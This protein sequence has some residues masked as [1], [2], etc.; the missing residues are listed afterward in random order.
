M[1]NPRLG[2]HL[3]VVHANIV[4]VIVWAAPKRSESGLG[5][6]RSRSRVCGEGRNRI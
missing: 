3:S 2:V 6:S 1:A 4:A 5:G